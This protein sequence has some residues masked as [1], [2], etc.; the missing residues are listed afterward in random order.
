VGVG[1]ASLL[2]EYAPVGKKF[3]E[4]EAKGRGKLTYLY[5]PRKG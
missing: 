2:K 5:D 1:L 3:P 4:M